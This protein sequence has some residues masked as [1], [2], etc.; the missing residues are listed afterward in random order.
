MQ[1]NVDINEMVKERKKKNMNILKNK[2]KFVS[3]MAKM[4]KILR[5][6]NEN[7]IKIKSMY[8]KKLPKGLLLEG[9][10]AIEAF[11]YVKEMDKLNESRP[12]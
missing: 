5:Q 10:E 11:K 6:E 1:E 7:I 2:I 3:K 9:K 8:G 4:Q 12:F